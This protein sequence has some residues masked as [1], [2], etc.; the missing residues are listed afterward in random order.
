MISHEIPDRPWQVVATDLFL[1]DNKDYFL[2]VDYYSRYFEVQKI[3]ST[4]S[5]TIINHLSSIF[6]RHGIPEVVMSDNASQYTSAEFT[7]FSEAY[8]FRHKTSSPTYAQSNGLAERT[9]RIAKELFTKCKLSSQDPNLALLNYRTTPVDNLA[10]PAQLLMGRQLRGTCPV[11]NQLLRPKHVDPADVKETREGIQA[12]QRKYYDRSAHPLPPIKPGEQVRMW[13]D[14]RWKPAD[15]LE[16]SEQPRSFVVQTEE[17]GEYRRN[18]TDLLKLRTEPVASE[19]EHPA[20]PYKNSDET[21]SDNLNSPSPT[22][23]RISQRQV[24]PP[25]RLGYFAPGFNGY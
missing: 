3:V 5:Q 25:E 9:V 21:P 10:S 12:R 7:A 6:A 24:K 1:W 13:K 23:R 11:S 20:S 14:S 8:G 15:V 18:R 4:S 19:N 22:V 16:Q 17:G 2:I